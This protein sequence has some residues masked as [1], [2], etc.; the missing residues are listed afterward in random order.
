MQQ[1]IL[2]FLGDILGFLN[3]NGSAIQTIALIATL[4]FLALQIRQNTSQ[5]KLN[6]YTSLS[7]QNRAVN[8]LLLQALS[9][10]ELATS[11]QL[12]KEALIAFVLL[13]EHGIAHRLLGEGLLDKEWWNAELKTLEYLVTLPLIQRFW[14]N[15]QFRSQYSLE[16]QEVINQMMPK[17][18]VRSAT[19]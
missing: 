1:Q 3:A 15:D 7:D 14:S 5:I 9:T 6:A 18:R 8:E 19:G 4:V 17:P 13:S 12:D 11:M 16:F 10:E 2:A